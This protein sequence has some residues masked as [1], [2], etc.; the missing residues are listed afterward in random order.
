MIDF[1]VVPKEELES[2]KKELLSQLKEIQISKPQSSWM[3]SKNVRELLNISDS[4]LQTL[5]INGTIPSY[6]LGSSWFYKYDEIVAVLEAGKTGEGGS[7]V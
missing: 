3:R 6:K 7:H 5:R 4:T 2:F 1:L